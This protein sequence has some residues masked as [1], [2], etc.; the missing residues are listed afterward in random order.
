M[1]NGDRKT[2]VAFA[3]FAVGLAF[4]CLWLV[5]SYT[6]LGHRAEVRINDVI[7]RWLI[8]ANFLVLPCV[9]AIAAGP[10]RVRLDLLSV[11]LTLML[12]SGLIL[13]VT[14]RRY[15]LESCGVLAVFALEVY[16]VIPKWK[17]RHRHVP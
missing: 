17:A 11:L 12:F 4:F 5:F 1:S 14:F 2:L 9:T 8:I 15:L 3:V 10:L 16:W 6:E 13:E 7:P